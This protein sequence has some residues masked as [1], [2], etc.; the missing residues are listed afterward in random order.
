MVLVA[1]FHFTFS[2][3]GKWYAEV[4]STPHSSRWL[5]VQ[6]LACTSDFETTLVGSMKHS[7]KDDISEGYGANIIS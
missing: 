7:G 1:A 4:L 5:H 2:L 3:V 6:V